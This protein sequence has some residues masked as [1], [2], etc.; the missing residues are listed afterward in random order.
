MEA[1]AIL[2]PIVRTD[3]NIAEAWYML[4]LAL[5]NR[6][7]SLYAFQ[8]VVRIDPSSQRAYQQIEKL[9]AQQSSPFTEQPATPALLP[10]I[11]P[12][13][14]PALLSSI[15]PPTPVRT[16]F[17]LPPVPYP[18]VPEEPPAPVVEKEK[19]WKKRINLPILISAIV[20]GLFF[21]SI[22]IFLISKN[23]SAAAPAHRTSAPSRATSTF[24]PTPLPSSSYTPTFRPGACPFSVPLGTR[25]RCGVVRVPQDRQKSLTTDL[26][27]L[28]VVLYQ[29]PKVDADAVLF[30]QGGP[31]VESIDWSLA[32]FQDYVSPILKDHDMIFFDPRGTG[33]SK[34]ALDCPELNAVFLDA[35]YQNRSQDDAFQDF[36]AAWN[37]CHERFIAT[38]VNPAVFNTTESAADV[39]DIVVA[40][41]YQQVNMLGISY[42]TRL[43]LTV[44]RDYP[45]IVRAMVLDS[46]VPLES[47]MFNRSATDTKY[48]LDKLFADCASSPRCNGAYPDLA[49]VFNELIQKFDKTP[50]TIRA[51][52]ASAE[53]LPTAKVNGVDMIG[54]IVAGMHQSELVPVIPK[55]IYDIHAGDYTFLSYAL[56][57]RGGDYNTTGLGTYFS[58]VCPEQVYVTTAE[59][60]D[61]DLNVSPLI[62]Q[63]ALN[64]LFGSARNLFDLCKAWDANP[65][66]PQD[67]LPVTAK[68]PTLIISGQYDP[69]TPS[70]TGEL[71]AGDLPNH[72]FYI[73]PGMG[74]GATVGN[75]CA[76]AIMMAFLKE[77]EKAP[78]STCLT[79]KPFEFFLPYDGKDPVD[80]VE[81]V[82][83]T[84]G[85]QGIAPVGWKKVISDGSYKR[86]AYLFDVT[87]VQA[88][89][90]NAP[91][92]TVLEELKNSFQKSGFSGSPKVMDTHSV[93][94][95][96]WTIYATKFNGEPV[97]VGLSQ[98]N[99]GRTLVLVMVV[100]AP[101][102]DA[103]YNGLFIPMMDALLPM[104]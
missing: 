73:I 26:I 7:K 42:G 33:R 75:A 34:P 96:L 98:T 40:L 91:K 57:A 41:G 5:T 94:G 48:A 60:L 80:A 89:A 17:A 99:T 38:G 6:E 65:D 88:T 39:H 47:K 36:L 21:L 32:T 50:V 86:R 11:E 44:M 10:S 27:E 70:T 72:Y 81:F 46:V 102:R 30:L 53:S 100:S 83:P 35:Y 78:D 58:T 22:A 82:D 24:G 92:S 59:Q 3:P 61:S 69:I 43:G 37:K 1:Q 90:Y 9:T 101:E 14:A 19:S 29:S 68:T 13:P 97:I 56:G 62:K 18:V 71:V 87:M 74:H 28:P 79:S 51:Y 49:Y 4:G 84:N 8:Q 77:P 76:S 103:F 93:N 23:G 63:F 67:D 104:W 95:L 2:I 66:D 25:V 54:A 52:A 31:G 20:L 16:V 15:E 12:S 45:E 64:G 85:V 55:A